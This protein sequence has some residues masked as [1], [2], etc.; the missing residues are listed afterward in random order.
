ME[1]EIVLKTELCLEIEFVLKTET[2]VTRCCHS[3]MLNCSIAFMQS[4]H[5]SHIIAILMKHFICIFSFQI[6]S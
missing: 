1:I 2:V 6:F 4:S 5:A 3:V